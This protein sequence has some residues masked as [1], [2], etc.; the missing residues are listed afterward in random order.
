M[1]VVT[2]SYRV[3]TGSLSRFGYTVTFDVAAWVETV[4]ACVP[5]FTLF[6]QAV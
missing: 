5:P 4:T 2:V 6:P 3:A 1:L